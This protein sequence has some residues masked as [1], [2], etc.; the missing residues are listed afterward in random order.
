MKKRYKLLFCCF[1][2]F[3]SG[4]ASVPTEPEA[5]AAY[6]ETNDPLEPMNRK[7]FAFNMAADKYVLRPVTNGYRAITTP[8][9]RSKV[10]TFLSNLKTPLTVVNDVIQLNLKNAGVDLSRFIINSTLGFFG[11][12][13][14]AD[15]MGL[16]PNTQDFGT[17][18]AVWDVPSGPYLVLPFLGPSNVRDASG[19]VGDIFLDPFYYASE[20]S[21]DDSVKWGFWAIDGVDAVASYENVVDLLDEGKKNS[22][23]F[24]A[25]MRSMYQQHRKKTI[26]RAKGLKD[27]DNAKADYDFALDD[28]EGDSDEDEDE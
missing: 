12:F 8:A 19:K 2:L 17:T 3:L 5:L 28:E 4:C 11:V 27:S 9:F 23:D 25:Y 15:R 10:R 18:M 7:I 24:Y 20:N 14:V 21:D 16:A 26:Q 1:L 22:L 13:D 6:R